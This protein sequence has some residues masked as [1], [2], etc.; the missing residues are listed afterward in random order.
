MGF[1]LRPARDLHIPWTVD[2]PLVCV[3]AP[4]H[5]VARMA[6]I[7]IRQVRAYPLVVQSRALAIR[8]MLEAQHSWLFTDTQAPLVT[9]SL[10]LL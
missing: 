7:E 6:V 1:N 3:C 9:I 8:R 10:Q 2:L 4:D 5:P